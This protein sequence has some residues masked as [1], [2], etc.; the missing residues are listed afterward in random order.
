MAKDDNSSIAVV[1][2]EV[3]VIQKEVVKNEQEE[4]IV[5]RGGKAY[6]FFKRAFDIVSSGLV[7]IVFSWLLI[8]LALLVKLTS[9]GPVLFKDER[10][11]LHGKKIKVYKFRSMYID[12]ETNVE[13]CQL[14]LEG[15]R[16]ISQ[17]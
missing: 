1:E 16:Q 11:G 3:E 13:K 6:A 8:I 15:K 7:I 2:Q 17:I 9:K 12:A 14:C 10:V 5:I 4:E